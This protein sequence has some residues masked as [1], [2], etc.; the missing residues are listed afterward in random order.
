MTAASRPAITAMATR[1]GLKAE[2][3]ELTLLP[4]AEHD[5]AVEDEDIGQSFCG[6]VPLVMEIYEFLAFAEGEGFGEK[7]WQGVKQNPVTEIAQQRPLHDPAGH[8]GADR[9]ERRHE[10]RIRRP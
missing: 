8:E 9:G 5:H 10:V 6:P 3:N 4:R 2:I 1:I 7:E